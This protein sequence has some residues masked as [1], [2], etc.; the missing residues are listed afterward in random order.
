M[1]SSAKAAPPKWSSAHDVV[2]LVG[3]SVRVAPLEAAVVAVL[4]LLKGICPGAMVLAMAKVIDGAIEQGLRPRPPAWNFWPWIAVLFGCLLVDQVGMGG[5]MA[6]S[7]TRLRRASRNL[8]STK[9]MPI[10]GA[11]VHGSAPQSG[12]W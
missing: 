7:S 12:I 3:Q 4:Q 5:A 1:A 6:Q 2:W 8:L 9:G 11:I 10:S